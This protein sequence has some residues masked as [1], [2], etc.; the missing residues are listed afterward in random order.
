MRLTVL[1][2]A[3]MRRVERGYFKFIKFPHPACARIARSALAH[4]TPPPA[5]REF[6]ALSGAP[7]PPTT[8]TAAIL[9]IVK[10]V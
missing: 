7:C 5:A 3:Q 4:A 1:N 6:S 9:K 8:S 10:S 2:R